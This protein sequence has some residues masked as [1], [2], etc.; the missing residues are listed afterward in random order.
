MCQ[1]VAVEVR[2]HDIEDDGVEFII[3]GKI[4]AFFSIARAHHGVTFFCQAFAQEF[5]HAHLVFDDQ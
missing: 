3:A 5:Y 1:V 2:Q 4:Q